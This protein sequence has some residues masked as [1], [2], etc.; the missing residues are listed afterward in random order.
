LAARKPAAVSC[1]G[2]N[3]TQKSASAPSAASARVVLELRRAKG[4]DERR[5]RPP[6]TLA[7]SRA[8]FDMF[9][10]AALAAL[11][12]VT[13]AL[14]STSATQA[15]TT[16]LSSRD[17]KELGTLLAKALDPDAQDF[18]EKDKALA[19]LRNFFEK[20]GKTR[21]PKDPMQGALAMT[22]DLS[23]AL[24]LS[25]DY[26]MSG[27]KLGQ[28]SNAEVGG[29][30]DPV[31]YA[32]WVPKNYKDA[33]EGSGMPLILCLPGAK[34]GK[35][36]SPDEYMN[37]NWSD[38]NVRERV[39]IAAVQ[40]PDD[41]KSWT[42]PQTAAGTAGGIAVVMLTLRDL[43]ARYAID[44]DRVYLCGRESGLP[45]ALSLASKF[46]QIFAGVI[47]RAGEAGGVPADNFRNLPTYFAGGGAESAAFEEST[48]KLGYNN[49]TLKADGNDA[50]ALAW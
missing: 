5:P 32:L 33:L 40:M 17:Q 31:K 11:A 8:T 26:R 14:A 15:P 13:L 28:V 43:R 34:D 21:N 36:L 42:E 16:E 30:K 20:A 49:C 6:E 27:V 7:A 39:M 45:A 4:D 47:G 35:T 22:G 41:V 25:A 1:A 46:P 24:H 23:K 44:F 2:R 37:D 3:D 12:A 18:K 48:K 9:Q 10:K 50:D 19:K 29:K 38:P